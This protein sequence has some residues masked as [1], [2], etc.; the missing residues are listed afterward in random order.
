MKRYSPR[1]CIEKYSFM[2]IR[3]PRF[4]YNEQ[5]INPRRRH[6]NKFE[7]TVHHIPFP[8]SV[9]SPLHP[10]Y[11]ILYLH[12][13]SSSR[14]EGFS[15]LSYLPQD[16]AIACFDFGGCGNRTEQEYISLGKKEAEEVDIAV[17]FLRS[18]NYKVALWGRSMGAVSALLSSE[19]DV[20]VADSPFSSLRSVCK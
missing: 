10:K 18:K 5:I 7:H 6:K 11:V 4:L 20:I 12:G 2:L 9:Y 14:Y 15:Q 8:L 19:C 16:I 1:A 17:R 13:N 3:P